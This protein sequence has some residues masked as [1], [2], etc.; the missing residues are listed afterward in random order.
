VHCRLEARQTKSLRMEYFEEKERTEA[1]A[2]RYE[3]DFLEAAMDMAASSDKHP[4]LWQFL[5]SNRAL[6]LQAESRISILRELCAQ[7]ALSKPPREASFNRALAV[8]FD[9]RGL[10]ELT[11][12]KRR[13]QTK[14]AGEQTWKIVWAL[15]TELTSKL[16]PAK[17]I[18]KFY[19]SQI[20]RDSRTW[21]SW[22]NYFWQNR[23]VA[24]KETAAMEEEARQIKEEKERQCKIRDERKAREQKKKMEKS[25]FSWRKGDTKTAPVADNSNGTGAQPYSEENW[26]AAV[27]AGKKDIVVTIFTTNGSGFATGNQRLATIT[28]LLNA[29]HFHLAA[30]CLVVWLETMRLDGELFK[31]T[32]ED[33]AGMLLG[34]VPVAPTIMVSNTLCGRI[35]DLE[36]IEQE[37]ELKKQQEKES[38]EQVAPKAL[39]MWERATGLTSYVKGL[40]FSSEQVKRR[41]ELDKL[42]A[43]VTSLRR[44]F[45]A[46]ADVYV[47]AEMKK[48]GED[49]KN[50]VS[51]ALL[52]P[53]QNTLKVRAIDAFAFLAEVITEEWPLY[54]L[55]SD[56]I[57]LLEGI[58]PLKTF[59]LN[60]SAKLL[61]G[62]LSNLSIEERDTLVVQVARYESPGENALR[63]FLWKE[64][65]DGAY[66]APPV[67][68][69][70]K[71]PKMASVVRAAVTKKRETRALEDADGSSSSGSDSDDKTDSDS[72][73]DSESDSSSDD[74]RPTRGPKQN[75]PNSKTA[76]GNKTVNGRQDRAKGKR[77]QSK[78]SPKRQS[79]ILVDPVALME[80][81]EAASRG[82]AAKGNNGTPPKEAV[83]G[84]KPSGPPSGPGASSNVD[85]D[86]LQSD[87]SQTGTS[88]MYQEYWGMTVLA[89]IGIC[90]GG[91]GF[92]GLTLLV[93]SIAFSGSSAATIAPAVE[94]SFK[95]TVLES[96]P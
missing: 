81:V 18:Q 27:K 21:I 26:T 34:S 48:G 52:E 70:G 22:G 64:A 36:S 63:T 12:S 47:N 57:K 68:A 30:E 83:N 31:L 6:V 15:R 59:N 69:S 40:V 32:E 3:A 85:Y 1:F 58:V 42:R 84:G 35:D 95:Q 39:S 76:K 71:D 94:E 56:R 50:R 60:D 43:S 89:W 2:E 11:T 72:D 92:V 45:V 25:W 75:R 28:G 20:P 65:T 8:L 53:L 86:D 62:L 79:G 54:F 44:A 74:E 87:A 9:V 93:G 82:S 38:A 73:P 4:L 16:T 55:S 49:V 51:L 88:F 10:S 19:E 24:A 91:L 78:Y 90:A 7:V 80:L 29:S 67:A 41:S 23:E 61:T 33:K 77:R 46:L 66:E 14:K 5:L 37:E 13:P 17:A 96:L